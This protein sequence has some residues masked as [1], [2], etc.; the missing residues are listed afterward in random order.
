M[1][2]MLDE[3]G[4]ETNGVGLVKSYHYL[5]DV[6]WFSFADRNKYLGDLDF[7]KVLIGML[8]SADY[9]KARR[10]SIDAARAIDSSLIESVST[11]KHEGSDTTHFNVVDEEGNVVAVTYT[12]N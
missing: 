1:F 4:Y 8:T 9:L 6:M 11:A 7:V 10:A 2:G 12:L 3:T 5:V